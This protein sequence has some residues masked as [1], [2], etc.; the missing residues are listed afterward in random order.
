MNGE[1]MGKILLFGEHAAVYGR[2]AVGL[3]LPWRLEARFTGTRA[4]D[5]AGLASVRLRDACQRIGVMTPPES[6]LEVRSG[7]PPGVGLGSS[8]AL[9]VALARAVGAE[10]SCDLWDVAHRAEH[11]FHGS[12]SGI[13]TGLAILGGV[14]RF[15]WASVDGVPM[16]KPVVAQ[17]LFLVVGYVP[18][19]GG[20]AVHVAAV[21][22][23]MQVGD[24]AVSSAI[25]R[26]GQISLEACALL[27]TDSSDRV[28]LLGSLADEA[29]ALLSSLGVGSSVLAEILSVARF[30]GATGGKISGGGGG[31]AFLSFVP[32]QEIGSKVLS[33]VAEHLP[34]GQ[35][36]AALLCVSTGGAEVLATYGWP[37]SMVRRITLLDDVACPA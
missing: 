19:V 32:D 11:A 3:G 23:R 7:I 10:D 29:D 15:M 37:N 30:A 22:R 9:C 18:R 14:Q 2:P 26:L 6:T 12:P 24:G 27:A 33:S 35:S 13:D 1:A 4:G 36:A 17:G 5:E 21:Q 34:A 28:D 8:A 16:A 20:T 31:G 25:D